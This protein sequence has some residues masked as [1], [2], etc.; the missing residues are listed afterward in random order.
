M[1]MAGQK[2]P[3]KISSSDLYNKIIACGGLHWIVDV[4]P[5]D[6]FNRY[7]IHCGTFLP[8]ADFHQEFNV[9]SKKR[10]L[11]KEDVYEFS[12]RISSAINNPHAKDKWKQKQYYKIY[13]YSK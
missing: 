12:H 2:Q 7:R 1:S 11:L 5:E 8:W 10:P 3:Q 6:D 9:V 4:R 13:I